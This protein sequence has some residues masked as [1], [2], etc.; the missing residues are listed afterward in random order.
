MKKFVYVYIL[1]HIVC[2]FVWLFVD[3]FIFR[4]QYLNFFLWKGNIRKLLS[5]CFLIFE[6]YFI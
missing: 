2:L 6:K 1:F 4:I 3:W 5:N